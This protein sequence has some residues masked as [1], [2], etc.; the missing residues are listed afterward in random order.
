MSR[1]GLIISTCLLC[2]LLSPA[3]GAS[4]ETYTWQDCVK[5][6]AK[7]HPDLIS[8]EEGIKQ[9]QADKKISASALYPQLDS[10]VSTSVTRST[11][12]TS[13][14]TTDSYQYGA[15]VD[16][17][18]FDGFKIG[19]DIKADEENIKAAQYSYK[20]TSSEVRA[21]LRAAFIR[22]L[23]TQQLLDLTEDIRDIRKDNLDLINL[24]YESGMEHKGA[25][26]TAKANLSQAEFEIAQAK[27][28]LEAA[29]R[30]LA[31]EM[32]KYQF[33]PM[34]V[35]GEFKVAQNSLE[36]PDLELLTKNNP[37]LGII[38]AQRNAASFGIK[39][40][41][42]QFY[43][44][45]SAQAGASKRSETW[46]PE[47]DGW[48]AGLTLSFPLFE[49][50]LRD[51]RVAKAKSLYYQAKADERSTQD[52]I[53]VTL[54]Q[55]WAV[56]RDA[57]ETVDVQK[58]FLEAA[59]ERAKIAE[60]QY[61]LGLLQFDNWIIIENDLVSAKKGLLNAQANALLAEADWIL[62][63]GET[64]EYAE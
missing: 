45:L 59:E 19:S 3:R 47:N 51:A 13:T 53:I 24:R 11:S 57:V 60:S 18:L 41:E 37:Q 28:S 49:G 17:I 31:K 54:E 44:Q 38:A 35:K 21:R 36:K 2:L 63:K 61:A 7:H 27:R 20:F 29:Q 33:S 30:A 34:A 39:S 46:P 64:L 40:A 4:Q 43:P 14:S 32:G 22:V 58:Q 1:Y 23:K 16:Q 56:M 15:N 26:L 25:M 55:T 48:N 42:S 62:A 6:A 12:S 8:A 10:S 9:N 50:G 5:E 52:S